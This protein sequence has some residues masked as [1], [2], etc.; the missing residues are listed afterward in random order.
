ML[1][2]AVRAAD[3]RSDIAALLL[4]LL[5]LQME[6]CKKDLDYLG[7][8]ESDAVKDVKKTPNMKLPLHFC[9][10]F[11]KVGYVTYVTYHMLYNKNQTCYLWYMFSNS[12]LP[13]HFYSIYENFVGT[14]FILHYMYVMSSAC[15]SAMQGCE[16]MADVLALFPAGSYWLNSL[17]LLSAAAAAAASGEGAAAGQQASA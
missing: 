7:R 14:V 6:L 11:E 13:L 3:S 8:A 9:S 2:C 4:L 1:L 17:L 12:K 16:A 5:L 15:W 10:T